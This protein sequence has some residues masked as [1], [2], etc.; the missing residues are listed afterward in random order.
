MEPG[1]FGYSVIAPGRLSAFCRSLHDHNR[2]ANLLVARS[3]DRADD[4]SGRLV[5]SGRASGRTLAWLSFRPPHSVTVPLPGA[6]T[7][8]AAY[9]TG[10]SCFGIRRNASATPIVRFGGAAPLTA[11]A[12]R[13]P[14]VLSRPIR[15][16]RRSCCCACA[17]VA[18]L[19][20]AS[21][22]YSLML[23][24]PPRSYPS[25]PKIVPVRPGDGA[26]ES[27]DF[28][29]PIRVFPRAAPLSVT[30]A[31]CIA[32]PSCAASSLNRAPRRVHDLAR[33]M[34]WVALADCARREAKAAVRSVLHHRCGAVCGSRALRPSSRH[35]P[36]S[37]RIPHAQRPS[38]R[39][40][41]R[42]RRSSSTG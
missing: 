41:R 5:A 9:A 12:C 7:V 33:G 8:L 4:P 35:R 2:P 22:P 23:P 20:A 16:A 10:R 40:S 13:R 26:L 19:T 1:I 30:A 21:S 36:S 24:A 42:S 14:P 28:P 6:P 11:I 37:V 39:I 3:W 29:R 18:C 27:H 15:R 25:I 34:S 32:R 17:S 38:A 31:Q